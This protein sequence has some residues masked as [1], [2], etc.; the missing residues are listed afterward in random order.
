MTE[1]EQSKTLE[2]ERGRETL[3]KEK[4]R[5]GEEGTKKKRKE[6]KREEKRGWLVLAN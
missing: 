2:R 5:G 4:K 6:K 3:K 1:T